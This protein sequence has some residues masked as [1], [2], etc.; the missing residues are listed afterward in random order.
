ME[1]SLFEGKFLR[2]RAPP[3]PPKHWRSATFPD[4]HQRN[5]MYEKSS[6]SIKLS[7]ATKQVFFAFWLRDKRWSV[8][9]NNSFLLTGTGQDIKEAIRSYSENSQVACLQREQLP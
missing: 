3:T 8:R 6:L 5:Q 1:K 4:L 2:S 7:F 9:S